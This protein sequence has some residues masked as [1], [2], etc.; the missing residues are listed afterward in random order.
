MGDVATLHYPRRWDLH[1]EDP[2]CGNVRVV[3]GSA[4]VAK[5]NGQKKGRVAVLL[6]FRQWSYHP[7]IRASTAE[8]E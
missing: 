2:V 7:L 3:D 1:L 6:W 4:D 5:G 8:A